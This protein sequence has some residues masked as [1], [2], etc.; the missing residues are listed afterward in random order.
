MSKLPHLKNKLIILLNINLGKLK[1]PFQYMIRHIEGGN[2]IILPHSLIFTLTVV[3]F[4][5]LT[6][7][8]T[9]LDNFLS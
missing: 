4:F 3:M 8:A 1:I 7:G 6:G 2:T 5:S 9:I